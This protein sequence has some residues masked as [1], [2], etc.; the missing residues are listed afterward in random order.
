MW[1]FVYGGLQEPRWRRE[2][3]LRD[4]GTMTTRGAMRLRPG[5]RDPA[6]K[7]REAGTV[8]GHLMLVSAKDMQRLIKMEAPEYHLVL[9]KRYPKPIWAFEDTA[10]MTEWSKWA[11]AREGS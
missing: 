2:Y 11:K 3:G 4:Y 7:F 10:P 6:A 1:L 5:T 9:L 8:Q